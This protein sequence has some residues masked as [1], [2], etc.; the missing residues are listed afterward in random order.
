M[1]I[2]AITVEDV[3]SVDQT[4]ALLMM[5]FEIIL[6]VV[7]AYLEEQFL[8]LLAKIVEYLSVFTADT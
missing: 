4:L 8:T 1:V 2:V 7:A 3:F 6:F 5:Q